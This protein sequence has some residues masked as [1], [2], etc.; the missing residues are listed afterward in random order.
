[1]IQGPLSPVE[2]VMVALSGFVIVFLMLALLWG[3][4][5]VVSR[6]V[7]G[8]EK[9]AAPVAAA[10]QPAA[11]PVAAPAAAP[12]P[13]AAAPQVVLEGVDE[14]QAACVMA[15]VS[16]ETGIPLDQLVFKSIKA[17]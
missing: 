2:A 9:K 4:I 13:A 11:A 5:I 7:G 12:A 14:T 1:M 6:I 17:V 3:V 15:I 8:V 10:S 16:H